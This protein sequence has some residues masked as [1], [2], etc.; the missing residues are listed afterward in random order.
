MAIEGR[1][2]PTQKVWAKIAVILTSV[3]TTPLAFIA[4]FFGVLLW[5]GYSEEYENGRH[6]NHAGG[7]AFWGISLLL[8]LIAPL[9]GWVTTR[10]WVWVA[11]GAALPLATVG[12][13]FGFALFA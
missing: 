13:I 10:R 6:G 1:P 11:A 12:T 4:W 8:V 9:L 2:P 5:N 3:V 7:L